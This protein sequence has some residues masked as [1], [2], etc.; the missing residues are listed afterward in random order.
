MGCLSHD[1]EVETV[2]LIRQSR[3]STSVAELVLSEGVQS[4][5]L[6][7]LTLASSSVDEYLL[8]HEGVDSRTS[9]LFLSG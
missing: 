9:R 1:P 4:Q 7:S 8:S 2:P 3:L 5:N 6:S